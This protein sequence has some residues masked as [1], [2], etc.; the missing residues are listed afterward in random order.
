MGAASDNTGVTG[1]MLPTLEFIGLQD[2]HELFWLGQL[3]NLNKALKRRSPHFAAEAQGFNSCLNPGLS[4][5]PKGCGQS[6]I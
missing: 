5:K 1:R 2:N 4:L 6:L 3:P